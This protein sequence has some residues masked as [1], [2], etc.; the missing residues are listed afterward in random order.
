M[1]HV[2]HHGCVL[3]GDDIAARKNTGSIKVEMFVDLEK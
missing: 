1:G 2:M 3:N